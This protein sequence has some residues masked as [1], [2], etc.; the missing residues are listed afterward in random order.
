MKVVCSVEI[1][2]QE[3][4]K[5]DAQSADVESV[6]R[7]GSST[8]VEFDKKIGNLV[9]KNS[10]NGI[11]FG[12]TPFVPLYE[13]DY[14]IACEVNFGKTDPVPTDSRRILLFSIENTYSEFELTRLTRTERQNGTC[15]TISRA[16]PSS[17]TD[18]RRAPLP[19]KSRDIL[20][21][22]H[23]TPADRTTFL[24]PPVKIRL[25]GSPRKANRRYAAWADADPRRRG[26]F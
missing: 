26:A 8:S 7:K 3:K 15:L 9:G 18:R 12:Y 1:E 10:V 23:V 13:I 11:Y 21:S 4:K 6:R 20:D 2:K 17:G 19:R 24:R 16:G 22:S 25:A 14:I 5:R